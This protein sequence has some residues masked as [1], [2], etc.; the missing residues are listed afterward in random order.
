MKKIIILQILINFFAS[1]LCAHP[2]IPRW[3]NTLAQCSLAFQ[4]TMNS[5]D[6]SSNY[7]SDAGKKILDILRDQP[8]S[9]QA[10]LQT[11]ISAN[12]NKLN[13][14]DFKAII[15]SSPADLLPKD[16]ISFEFTYRYEE[17]Y[18]FLEA[19]RRMLSIIIAP[20]YLN[21]NF[22]LIYNFI[23][24]H[25]PGKINQAEALALLLLYRPQLIES[26]SMFLAILRRIIQLDSMQY[27]AFIKTLGYSYTKD[28]NKDWFRKLQIDFLKIRE[29]AA[30][31]DVID[32][33][34]KS[35]F[36]P[37]YFPS[38]TIEEGASYREFLNT[39][40]FHKKS[41]TPSGGFVE[42]L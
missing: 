7:Q 16:K 37:N 18:K 28:L 23:L 21:Q 40:G 17:S 10:K 26:Q 31:K 3:K 27:N 33:L 42:V 6:F 13:E 5:F 24:S 1:I 9:M 20:N 25:L 35:F 36:Q 11:L 41:I 22:S 12:A 4:S 15:A 30:N 32:S 2:I 14:A 38:Y 29:L 39:K 34:D 8:N 19:S